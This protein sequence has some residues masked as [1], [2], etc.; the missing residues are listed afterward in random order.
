MHWNQ[1]YLVLKREYLTRVKSKV[2]IISTLLIPL[3]FVAYI[4]LIIGIQFWES[5]PRQDIAIHDQTSVLVDRLI[6]QNEERYQNLSDVSVDSIRTLVQAGQMDGYILL[7]EEHVT[8]NATPEFIYTGSSSMALQ[9]SIRSELR[10]VIREER[11]AR[12]EVTEDVRNIFDSTVALHSRK[13]TE[14]GVEEEDHAA[15]YSALGFILGLIIFFSLFMYGTIIMRGVIEEKSNRIIEVIASSIRPIE[16]LTGKILGITSVALTQFLVWTGLIFLIGLAA[17]PLAMMLAGDISVDPA[18]AQTVEGID[19]AT[20]QIPAVPPSLIIL[21]FTF[22]ILGYFLYSALFASIGSAVDSES[23]TQ[24][25]MMP[26]FILLFI[27]FFLNVEVVQNPDSA[28][29]IFG[30]L[31][32]FFAPMNMITRL[33]ISSVPFWQ[34]A[35]SILLMIATIAGTM[36]LSARIYRVGILQYGGKAGYKDLLKWFRQS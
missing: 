33:A 9:A 24:Q 15:F 18:A 11:L 32:P 12:A 35:V 10:E 26:V 17:S 36:L 22:F 20:F 19:P 14:T 8:G 30:S 23:D 31:F 34:I 25:L 16:L 5:E 6:E 1:I 27:G 4:A 2:F 28:L 21:F 3:G 29:S 13:L 7:T